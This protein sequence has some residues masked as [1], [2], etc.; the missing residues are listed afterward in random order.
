MIILD[1]SVLSVF[2]R[3]KLLSQLEELI[4]EAI[5]SEDVLNEY[6]EHWQKKIP[7]WIKIIEP[8]E[9][10][11]VKSSPISLSLAD[12]TLI[13]LAL[14]YKIPIASDD[15]PLRLFAKKL[16]ISITGS[17]GILKILYQ[18]RIIKTRKEYLKY[19]DSL[20]KDIYISDKLMKW[21]LEE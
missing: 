16:G 13:K 1:N 17:L 21:A 8:K 2:T 18:N 15:K 20:Q 6:S 5:I 7:K 4:P 11:Q 14:E 9:N 19:L 10:I 12:L 3:L